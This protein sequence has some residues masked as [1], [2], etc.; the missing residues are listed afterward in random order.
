MCVLIT[1]MSGGFTAERTWQARA[2][3]T[4]LCAVAA[5]GGRRDELWQLLGFDPVETRSLDRW[6]KARALIFLP[7]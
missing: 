1:N 5:G 3:A 2:A 6:A 4:A 7:T